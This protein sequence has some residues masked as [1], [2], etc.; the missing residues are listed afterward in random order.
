M[1]SLIVAFDKNRC[2]GSNNGIPWKL[3]NDMKRVKELTTNQTILM[4]R[5]TFDSIGRPLPNRINRVLTRN[6]TKKSIGNL[7]FYNDT[8]KAIENYKTDKLF[9]FGGGN[10]YE[11]YIDICEEMFITIVDTKI[12]GDAFFPEIDLNNWVILS[13]QKFFS[14]DENEFDYTY[15]HIKKIKVRS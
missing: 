11:Q 12:E 7:E 10:I 9:I 4:G 1:I 8:K 13:E 15:I 5:K 2:I 14:D 6:I 3:K